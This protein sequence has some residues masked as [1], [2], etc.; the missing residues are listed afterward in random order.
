MRKLPL[1]RYSKFIL[2]C[3]AVVLTTTLVGCSKKGCTDINADNYDVEATKDDGAC[4][5]PIINTNAGGDGDVTGG[6][7][8]ASST[9]AWTSPGTRAEY[10]MDITAASGGTFNLRILDAAQNEVLNKTLTG[11]S[12]PDTADGLTASGMAGEWTVILT[13]TNFA[14]DGSYSI[15]PA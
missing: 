13:L 7:G 10:N 3:F 6:G 9:F 4:T 8:S 1:L 5:Y 12:S 11:G 2:L 15:D 14:G